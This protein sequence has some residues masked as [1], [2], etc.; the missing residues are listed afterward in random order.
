MG[1][2]EELVG[3][4]ETPRESNPML[5]LPAAWGL[6]AGEKAGL[7]PLREQFGSAMTSTTMRSRASPTRRML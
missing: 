6:L 7:G 5:L 4:D 3:L 1:W 2:P